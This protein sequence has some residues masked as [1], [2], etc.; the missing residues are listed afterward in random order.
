MEIP[1]LCYVSEANIVFSISGNIRRPREFS[2]T[3]LAQLSRTKL[4]V[5]DKKCGSIT[6]EG[7]WLRTIFE[8]AEVPQGKKLKGEKLAFFLLIEALDG[9][10]IVYALAEFD[11]DFGNRN[12]LLADYRDGQ[13]LREDEAPLRL[14]IPGERRHS[15]WIRKIA[16]MKVLSGLPDQSR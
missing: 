6:Y 5:D 15:R 11:S 1:E 16:H 3:D 2:A 13:P 12:P 8:Q 9:H 4:T 10:Q 14:I 7:V